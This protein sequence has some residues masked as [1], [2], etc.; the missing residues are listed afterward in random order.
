MLCD[1]RRVPANIA[2]V[3][4]LNLFSTISKPAESCLPAE[5]R[6]TASYLDVNDNLICGGVVE[7]IAF[8]DSLTQ[9]LNLEIRPWNFREFVGEMNR[10]RSTAGPD[11]LSV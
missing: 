8:Q 10:R 6:V 4:P 9:S 11:G 1:Q 5:I 2:A 3:V 7:N